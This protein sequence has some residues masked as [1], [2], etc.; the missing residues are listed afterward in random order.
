MNYTFVV[1][2]VILVVVLYILYKV[3]TEKKTELA[4]YRKLG[5]TVSFSD[6]KNPGSGSYYISIWLYVPNKLDADTKIYEI[7]GG[8]T[9]T[10]KNDNSLTVSKDG[11]TPALFTIT[12]SFPLQRWTCVIVSVGGGVIDAYLDGKMVK[13]VKVVPTNP[14]ASSTLTEGEQTNGTIY[15]AK[16]E[17]IPKVI[18]AQ[19]AYEI[20]MAGNG[21]NGLVQFLKRFGISLTLTKDSTD[22]STL[23]FPP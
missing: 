3:F 23:S 22:Q 7:N 10:L 1:L 20:Y 4:T 6:L 18:D 19:T 16:F 17:R 12:D 9:L 11:G 13:S 8:L 2:G 14:S 15:I 5:G 21:G